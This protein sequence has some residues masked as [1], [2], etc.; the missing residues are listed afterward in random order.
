M[1]P[2]Q[3]SVRQ[4]TFSHA[5]SD[6]QAT[7]MRPPASQARPPHAPQTARN[8]AG[9]SLGLPPRS[10]DFGTERLAKDD[11]SSEQQH[12]KLAHNQA[13]QLHC[14]HMRDIQQQMQQQ[15]LSQVAQPLYDWPFVVP[16]SSSPP[17]TPRS[18]S[19]RVSNSR[20]S[21]VEQAPLPPLHRLSSL[22][23][24]RHSQ[25][26]SAERGHQHV[27]LIPQETNP[28]LAVDDMFDELLS[29]VDYSTGLNHRTGI[30]LGKPP[31]ASNCSVKQ[32]GYREFPP[33]LP[34]VHTPRSARG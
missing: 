12:D 14:Q 1:S 8:S 13:Q 16:N 24:S 18:L 5:K 21:K 26:S 3:Q 4:A 7:P 27:A 31:G 15:L 34:P 17:K 33:L 30:S 11:C 32:S 9:H 2:R 22:S 29:T 19:A 20:L 10:P 25:P 23:V 28:G 6:D